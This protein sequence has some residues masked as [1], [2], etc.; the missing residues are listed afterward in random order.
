[1]QGIRVDPTQGLVDQQPLNVKSPSIFGETP[2]RVVSHSS[3]QKIE[4]C[5]ILQLAADA[6]F[7]AHAGQQA[8]FSSVP[9]FTTKAFV[10]FA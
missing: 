1:M 4:F 10:Q 6:L 8:A 2:Q 5:K 9:L 7:C 3:A